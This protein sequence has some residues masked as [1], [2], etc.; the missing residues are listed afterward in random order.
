MPPT[1]CGGYTTPFHRVEVYL[2]VLKTT[3]SIPFGVIT[4]TVN[5]AG[6]DVSTAPNSSVNCPSR[7]AITPPQ[8]G[9][10]HA[11]IAN[12]S[13]I[14]ELIFVNSSPPL[15]VFPSISRAG[16]TLVKLP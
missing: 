15:L 11:S 13:F 14:K 9:T 1:S 16:P 2:A 6:A 10:T 4:S 5:F 8:S 12:P 7:C 3:G